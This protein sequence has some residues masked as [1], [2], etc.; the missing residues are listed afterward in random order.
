MSSIVEVRRVQILD[1]QVAERIAAGEVIERP[2][3]VVK[4][5]VENSLDA[6]ATEIAV[7]LEE[8]GKSLIEVLDNGH[9]M[10]PE[11]L[12]LCIQRHATSKLRTL[13]D[14]ERILSLGFRGEALPS[15]TAVSDVSLLSCSKNSDTTFQLNLKSMA[16][17]PK[18]EAV[19]FG[20]FLNSPHGTRI[21]ARGLFSQVPA[22]LKFLKSQNAEVAQVR[23]WIERLA[24][25]H[26]ATGFRLTS[27]G[28]TLLNLRPQ[29]E[30]ER[31]R[32]LLGD[33][34]DFPIVFATEETS[35]QLK[36]R[37]HWLQGLSTPQTRKLIQVVN[38][39]S[40]RDRMLQQAMLAPF[41]QV[42]FQASF[43][44]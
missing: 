26:P 28:R 41:R 18:P 4:E 40:V 21:Q 20:H 16:S 44:R 13:D 31:I 19:T 5:L 42:L 22:R 36:I 12:S 38:G 24:L 1:P 10:T 6:G 11:D 34:D 39:R 3:S 17:A 43:P 2:A 25:A 8:G 32:T 23:E 29:T 7:N 37:A 15:I 27:D 33:G 14:L 30:S 35:A 9:G